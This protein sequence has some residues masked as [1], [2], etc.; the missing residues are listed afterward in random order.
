MNELYEKNVSEILTVVGMIDNAFWKYKL[1]A[2]E[3]KRGPKTLY[4]PDE[5]LC[6]EASV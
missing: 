1:K 2:T 6:P 3:K 5:F 4:T